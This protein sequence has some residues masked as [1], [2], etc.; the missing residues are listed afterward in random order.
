MRMQWHFVKRV[1]QTLHIV[2]RGDFVVLLWLVFFF[3][4]GFFWIL[5]VGDLYGWKKEGLRQCETMSKYEEVEGFRGNKGITC[6]VPPNRSFVR[7]VSMCFV[8]FV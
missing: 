6:N 4:G 5:V 7:L 2:S 8:F 1:A 3:W